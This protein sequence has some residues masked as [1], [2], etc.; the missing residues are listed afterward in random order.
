MRPVFKRVLVH[1]GGTAAVL[2][3]LGFALAEMAG[4]WL[5]GNATTRSTDPAA[6]AQLVGHDLRY[7]IPATMA[8]WGFL[9]VAIGELSLYLWRGE[10]PAPAA[11]KPTQPDEAE[12]LLEELMKQAD[13]AMARQAAG[14]ET[15]AG[16]QESA[17]GERE[18]A[19]SPPGPPTT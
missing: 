11:R 16:S 17:A 9:F 5:A 10:P 4:L 1:G 3:G 18:P 12:L 2:A 15:A 14:P 6:D 19:A 13:E 7:R 8:L